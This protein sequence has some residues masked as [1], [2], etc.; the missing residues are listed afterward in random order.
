MARFVHKKVGR[1][2]L[3]RFLNAE[4]ELEEEI[5]LAWTHGQYKSHTK[6]GWVTVTYWQRKGALMSQGPREGAH[7]TNGGFVE[8]RWAAS[9]VYRHHQPLKSDT[10]VNRATKTTHQC[11]KYKPKEGR[12]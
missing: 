9:D 5:E 1:R 10:K 7:R 11:E 12:R 6:I 8:H 3:R 2:K 4:S